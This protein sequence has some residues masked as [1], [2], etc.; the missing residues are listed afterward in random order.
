M[1][2]GRLRG[3]NWSVGLF[4]LAYGSKLTELKTGFRVTEGCYT[5]N[6][7]RLILLGAQGQPSKCDKNG[8]F[9]KF[10]QIQIYDVAMKPA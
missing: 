7:K 3:G 4:D 1:M 9:P 6:G 5:S 8:V 10:G 2:G